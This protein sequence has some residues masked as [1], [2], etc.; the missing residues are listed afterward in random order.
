MIPKAIG[1]G[2]G[3]GP[4]VT[5]ICQGGAAAV[6]TRNLIS[7]DTAAREMEATA[8]MSRRVKKPA[9]HFVLTWP[10]GENP[11]DE[12]MFAAADHSLAGLRLSENQ[13][14]MAVHR[15][16]EHQHIHIVVNVVN[17][18][19]GK[20]VK[21]SHDYRKLEQAAREIERRQGWSVGAGK[22]EPRV[23]VDA[24]G[25]EEVTLVEVAVTPIAAV[26][27]RDQLALAHEE[28]TGHL[29]LEDRFT[30]I[31]IA[32]A[33]ATSWPDLDA[34]LAAIGVS[35]ERKGSGAVFIGDN[36][37]IS[38]ASAV[39]RTAS[40]SKLEKR[41][42]AMQEKIH[43]EPIREASSRGAIGGDHGAGGGGTLEARAKPSGELRVSFVSVRTGS[44][45]DALDA[46]KDARRVG[47]LSAD[48]LRTLSGRSLDAA[49]T[50]RPDELL[51]GFE[52]AGGLPAPALRRAPLG[53]S[54][55][56]SRSGTTALSRR[57]NSGTESDRGAP[58]TSR[59]GGTVA[60]AAD[61]SIRR[62]RFSRTPCH[63]AVFVGPPVTLRQRLG[64]A[65]DARRRRQTLRA[66]YDLERKRSDA[67][68]SAE[69]RRMRSI[70]EEMLAGSR[71]EAR[72]QR[73]EMKER[74][75]GELKNLRGLLPP[76]VVR[77]IFEFFMLLR[78]LREQQKL[79]EEI[80]RQ[81]DE[82]REAFKQMVTPKHERPPAFRKWLSQAAKNGRLEAMQALDDLNIR[83]GIKGS[84]NPVTGAWRGPL[85]ITMPL[86]ARAPGPASDMKR[87]IESEQLV[88]QTPLAIAAK[89]LLERA[90]LRK[91]VES[92]QKP[93]RAM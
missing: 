30:E 69:R 60:A 68:M 70:A 32:V 34:K 28:R 13:A 67:A 52:D 7:V 91:A 49:R 11:S 56:D 4:R 31:T 33:E 88:E 20:A 93:G 15:D 27:R 84:I 17:P 79:E 57:H 47:R 51:S 40:L 53:R 44:N 63:G 1:A 61:T 26:G 21:L 5:Y 74:H 42:G 66:E 78:Q 39:T 48:R 14:V 89:Q 38:K 54:D 64:W 83:D 46:I 25:N 18:N 23:T 29:P 72:S 75:K 80:V 9:Y 90:K 50:W 35:I 81:R 85:R 82:R 36:G 24:Q 43:G 77:A 2:E 92:A 55:A 8:E 3:F 62:L 71:A 87:G 45:A 65:D 6:E 10:G 22:Y 19:S 37:E 76:G 86:P 16:R 41:F 59:S 73:S 58:Q 12:Q